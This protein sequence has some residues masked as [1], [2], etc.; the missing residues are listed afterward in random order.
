MV[1]N[2]VAERLLWPER[3]AVGE[4]ERDVARLRIAAAR[5][6]GRLSAEQAGARIACVAH[7]RTRGDLRTVLGDLPDGTAPRGLV[8]A[9]RAVTALWAGVVAVEFVVWALIVLIGLQWN[10][11]WWLWALV[12]GPFAVGP[13]WWMTETYYRPGSSGYQAVREQI[14]TR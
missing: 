9:L 10:E 11:P 8:A 3:V 7:A 14:G 5:D 12:T 13:L 4:A 6:A 2:E 1:I